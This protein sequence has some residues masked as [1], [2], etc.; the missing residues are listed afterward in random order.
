V[1]FPECLKGLVVEGHGI[2]IRDYGFT[3]RV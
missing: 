3:I 2:S 1:V